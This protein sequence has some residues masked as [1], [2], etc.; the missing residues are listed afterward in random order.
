M[1]TIKL[2][3]KC[4]K[5]AYILAYKVQISCLGDVK[6]NIGKIIQSESGL[7]MLFEAC[8]RLHKGKSNIESIMVG[9][10]DILVLASRKWIKNGR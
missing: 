7:Y 5:L 1:E 3:M 9:D 6:R 4:V 2:I 10:E 8:E